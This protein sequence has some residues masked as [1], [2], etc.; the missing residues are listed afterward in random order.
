MLAVLKDESGK[1][2]G[3]AV[4]LSYRSAGPQIPEGISTV[5]V[6]PEGSSDWRLEENAFRGVPGWSH[7][8]PERSPYP[9][10]EG[11]DWPTCPHYVHLNPEPSCDP[12]NPD[13]PLA[14]SPQNPARRI[15][16]P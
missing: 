1:A 15:T 11:E 6:R 9:S 16:N 4:T 2:I 13:G 10:F 14:P 3:D 8:E 7:A 12:E 5:Y